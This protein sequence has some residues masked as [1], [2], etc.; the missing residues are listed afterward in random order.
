MNTHT[1]QSDV[2]LI[3]KYAYFN[4]KSKYKVYFIVNTEYN[5]NVGC[6][7][8]LDYEKDPEPY[9]TCHGIITSIPLRTM[10][11]KLKIKDK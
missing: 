4:S 2:P 11:L 6:H 3:G 9:V 1:S 7:Y 10:S 5:E 8:W